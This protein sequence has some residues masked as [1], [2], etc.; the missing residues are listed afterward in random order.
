MIVPVQAAHR[1]VESIPVLSSLWGG[2]GAEDFLGVSYRIE[3]ELADPR[4]FLS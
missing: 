4:E 3:G 1:V 2:I